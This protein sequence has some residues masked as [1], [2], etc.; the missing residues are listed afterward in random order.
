[1]Y[2]T[3]TLDQL[4]PDH[5]DQTVTLSG[6][7]HQRRDHGGLIF[8]VLRDRYG[9]TQI[10]SD[11]QNNAEIHEKMD[12]LR[13]EY[14]I[15]V[16]G[17]VRKRPEGMTNE[18]METGGIEVLVNEI[19]IL[20]ESLTPPFEI[21]QDKTVG[22]ELRLK[23]RYLDL[24]RSRMKNNLVMRHKFTKMTRDLFDE[25]GFI[26]VETPILIKGT[27]EGSREYIVP[28]RL[29]P[30]KCFVLPQS[31]QQLKQLLR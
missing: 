5:D 23:Y 16:T 25:R 11:P 8:V 3:H 28:S 30:G 27:P 15:Q 29:Y 17:T 20:N 10:V 4:G 18:N 2:R 19:E 22:E 21:D 31:S 13:S 6:W 7:V 24:R 9:L 14:V 26:E 1:M 12:K